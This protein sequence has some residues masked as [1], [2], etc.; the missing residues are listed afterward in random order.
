MERFQHRSAEWRGLRAFALTLLAASLRLKPLTTL[1]RRLI[2]PLALAIVVRG[3][4]RPNLREKNTGTL[5]KHSKSFYFPPTELFI[6][7]TCRLRYLS[8]LMNSVLHTLRAAMMAGLCA[9]LTTPAT[10]QVPNTLKHSI[11]ARLG[12]LQAGAQLGYSVAVDGQYTVVGAPFD[13]IVGWN[14]G[15]VK[16]FN[17]TTGALLFVMANPDPAAQDYFG[18]S[19]AISG[20]RVVVGVYQDDTGATNAGSAYVYDLSSGTP[21]VPVA[22]LN[23]P[24]PA[25]G[26]YFGWSVAI[27]GLQVVVG[28]PDSDIG[29]G[30]AGSAYV[31][32]LGSG[33]PTVPMATLSNPSPAALDRFGWSVTISGTQVVVGAPNDNTGATG[34]GSAYVYDVGSG[35]PTVPVATLNNPGPAASDSFGNSVAISGTRVVV[36]AYQDDAGASNAG[37]AY[38]YDVNSG[39]P[40]VPVA[41]LNNPSPAA[42]DNFGYSVAISGTRV[43]VGAYQDDTGASNAGSAYVYDVSSGTPTVPVATLNNPGPAANDNF[44]YSVAIS[45]TRVVA[46]AYQ[47]DTGM[48]DAGSAYVYDVSSGTP[49]VPVATLNNPSS[50]ANDQFGGS[51][52][53]SGTRVVVG[54]RFDDTGASDAGSAYVYDLSSGTPTVPLVLLNNPS[55]AAGDNFG[56]A[57][58]IS[59]TRVVVGARFDDT[60]AA[61][62]GSAYVYDLSSGTPTVP[63]ATL[64]NPSPAANEYFGSI[65]AI[66]GTRVVV[67]AFLEGG[68]QGSPGRTYVY[69]LSSGTPTVPVVW[70]T[71]PSQ[72]AGDGLGYLNVAIFGT[73]MVFGNPSGDTGATDA[74][75]AYVYDMSSGT[76]TLPVV[77]INNP[78]PAENDQFGCSIG[79]SGTRLVVGACRDDTGATDAGSVYV[80]DLSSGTPTVPIATLN[81][82]SPA[83]GDYFGYAVAISG[84]RVVVGSYLA[85]IGAADAGSA[86]V[87]DLSSG[88][89]TVPVATLTKPAPAS[90]DQ[91]GSAVAIAGT[92]VAI[93]APLD[94]TVAFD[95]GYAYVFGPASNDFDNDGLLD[96]WEYARFGSISAHSGLDDS[97]GDGRVELLEQAFN[98]NPLLPDVAGAPQ[99]VDEGGYLTMTIAKR[100]GVTYSV[101]SAA[102][103]DEASFSA[104]TT[105][106]LVNDATTLKVRDNVVVGSPLSRFMRV[107]VT[108]AP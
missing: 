2:E 44:G 55:P 3:F 29:A 25:A 97:D 27:S 85:D 58:A 73:R 51:I 98:T 6:R 102:T 92:T 90:V 59:D 38:V 1:R 99:A 7:K 63:I 16:V 14:S 5:R 31:Y 75:T 4:S 13:D 17:S 46:G 106:V 94:D 33:T 81:N 35:T 47:D 34:A 26:D 101:Q 105:T 79:I 82:P 76:P 52:A 8:P 41:T 87:Y 103:P 74:G 72:T 57:V 23:N 107:R 54:A 40:T 64:N 32:N 89:P 60:Y 88:T 67:G 36:G 49:T 19:V 56:G 12:G 83:A 108:A 95:Q 78:G 39:T 24:N 45:G 96:I 9:I 84:T 22:T 15:V 53:I 93:S 86:Y 42:N 70:F 48:N 65:V 104:A 66:S 77:T 68:L 61:E 37:S 71:K 69:D 18:Y 30:S 50:A 20:T 11:S 43:V 10:A 80:Y 28:T 91:F 62:S 100:A 21:T